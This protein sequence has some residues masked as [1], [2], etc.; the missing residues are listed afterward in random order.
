MALIVA[1][2]AGLVLGSEWLVT[3]SVAF[4]KAWA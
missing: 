2:L 3:A 4:A 1:G